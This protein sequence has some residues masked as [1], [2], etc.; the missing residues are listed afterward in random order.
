[1]NEALRALIVWASFAGVGTPFTRVDPVIESDP[2]EI[3]RA[4]L[5]EVLRAQER[6]YETRPIA[7][8]ALDFGIGFDPTGYAWGKFRQRGYAAAFSVEKLKEGLEWNFPS[9]RYRL[10]F[11]RG[12]FSASPARQQSPVAEVPLLILLSRAFEEGR[13]VQFGPVRYALLYEDGRDIPGSLSLL[14]KDEDGIFWVTYNGLEQA[15]AGIRWFLSVNGTLFGLRLE[16][17]H[18]VFYKKPA[19]KDSFSLPQICASKAVM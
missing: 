1:M 4:A 16:G 7:S 18:I 6:I 14:R 9:S 13:Q 17:E 10:S 11:S 19:R 8:A 5:R 15:R 12:N 3:E 2:T